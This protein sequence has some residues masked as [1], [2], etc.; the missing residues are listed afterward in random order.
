MKRHCKT[1]ASSVIACIGDGELRHTGGGKETV[2]GGEE[3]RLNALK[4]LHERHALL[5][6]QRIE[7][8]RERVG[9]EGALRD[10]RGADDLMSLGIQ[11]IRMG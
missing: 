5:D 1:T 6:P 10:D 2:V 7:G 4:R 11:M 3:D 8:R 9:E